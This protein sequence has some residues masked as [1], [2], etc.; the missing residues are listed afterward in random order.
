MARDLGT[1][2]RF[3]FLL[4]NKGYLLRYLKHLVMLC[5]QRSRLVKIF[6]MDDEFVTA[7]IS[8]YCEESRFLILPCIPHEHATL[9]N[10][11]RDNRTCREIIIKCIDSKS[12]LS[13]QYWGMR[14]KD[15]L[16]KWDIMP[17][18]ADP[19]RCYH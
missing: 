8:A 5:N 7:E 16:C 19:T 15:L 11:E 10:I 4:R 3:G 14:F 17:D 1:R 9:G 13:M 6:H 12:H 18:P 2:K